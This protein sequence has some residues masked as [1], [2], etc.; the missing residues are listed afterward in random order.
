METSFRHF[1][2]EIPPKVGK[3]MFSQLVIQRTPSLALTDLHVLTY[4]KLTG[5]AHL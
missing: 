1:S 2:D 4:G 5:P 3:P